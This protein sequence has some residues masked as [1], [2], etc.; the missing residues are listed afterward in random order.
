MDTFQT[1]LNACRN[2]QKNI[3]KILLDRG[4]IDL[5]RR[6]AE[7]NTALHYACRQGFRDI[8]SM[9]LD[10]GADVTRTNNRSE[11]PLHAAARNGNREILARLI[12]AGANMDAADNVGCTPL[13]RLMENRRTD[14]ALWLIDRGA[15]TEATDQTGHRALDYATAHGL[16][17]VVARL[18]QTDAADGMARD[19]DGNTPLHQAVYNDQAEVVR[20]LLVASKAQLDAP[21]MRA[22]RRCWWRADAGICTLPGCSSMPGPTQTGR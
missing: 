13:M 6:D 4:C 7:G 1:F 14:A 17:E 9:L 18:T 8:I 10:H 20:T 22:K 11:T 19:T 12:E 5:N 21:K 15:D 2:G 16:T 3:V